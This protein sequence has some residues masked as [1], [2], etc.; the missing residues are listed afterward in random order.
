M[1]TKTESRKDTAAVIEPD[2]ELR[3]LAQEGYRD[4]RD[5]QLFA[6]FSVHASKPFGRS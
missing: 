4:S 2:D 6:S 5:L 1:S 3:R